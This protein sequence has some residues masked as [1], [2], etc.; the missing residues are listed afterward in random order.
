MKDLKTIKENLPI[1]KFVNLGTVLDF[2]KCEVKNRLLN[3]MPSSHLTHSLQM[4]IIVKEKFNRILRRV[5]NG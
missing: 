3:Y 1:S 4:Y 5:E 2:T